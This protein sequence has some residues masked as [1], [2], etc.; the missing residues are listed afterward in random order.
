MNEITKKE[1][2]ET[3]WD[4]VAVRFSQ[5]PVGSGK[6]FSGVVDL[7]TNQKLTWN[8]TSTR[9][10]GQTF[11]SKALDQSD[12]PELLREV[13][14]ARA[15]LIEQVHGAW[16][17]IGGGGEQSSSNHKAPGSIPKVSLSKALNPQLQPTA[18]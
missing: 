2:V 13:G 4:Y 12:E 10:D 17:S 16:I 6:R 3:S 9:D 11:E 15:A 1:N 7:L 18:A 8:Q 5:I 14:E